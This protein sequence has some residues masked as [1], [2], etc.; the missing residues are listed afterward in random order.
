LWTH[1]AITIRTHR[2]ITFRTHPAITIRA[3]PAITVRIHGVIT[4]RTHPAITIRT[5]R[6]IT[7]PTNRAITFRFREIVVVGDEVF[8]GVVVVVDPGLA[9]VEVRWWDPF[10]APVFAFAGAPAAV[11]D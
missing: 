2:V 10:G 3:H 11:F 1:P 4:F 6:V 7:I 9:G 5:H 8:F